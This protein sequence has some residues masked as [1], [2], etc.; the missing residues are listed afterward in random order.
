MTEYADIPG[1][2]DIEAERYVLGACIAWPEEIPNALTIFGDSLP[3]TQEN[4]LSIWN[5][6]AKLHASHTP[7]LPTEIVKLT[8][9]E[10]VISP[11][12]D[13]LV[14]NQIHGTETAY[15]SKRLLHLQQRRTIGFKAMA[16]IDAAANGTVNGEL[17]ELTAACVA[18]ASSDEYAPP[19]PPVTA[20]ELYKSPPIPIDWLLKPIFA[21]GK[22]TQ[23]QGEP[24]AG[25]SV[26]ALYCAICAV[27]GYWIAGE[28]TSH[29]KPLTVLFL[30][31]EDASNVLQ[32][33]ITAYFNGLGIG[34]PDD[35][36]HLVCYPQEKCYGL[37]I[38]LDTEDGRKNIESLV[39]YTAA[40]ILILDSLSNFNTMEENSKKEMQPVMARLRRIAHN[41]RC[42]LMYLHHIGKPQAGLQ[43]SRQAKSRGSG[44]IAAAWDILIDWGDRGDSDTTPMSL[45]SKLG[46]DGKWDVEY[47]KQEDGSIKWS[48]GQQL[49][50]ENST[51]I[52]RKIMDALKT[53]FQ[54]SP[55]GVKVSTIAVAIGIS[56]E[57]VRT[58]LESAFDAGEVE[59][60]KGPKNAWLYT[61]LSVPN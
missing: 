30:S 54:S 37:D 34:N 46:I 22:L 9:R 56:A 14:A 7:V 24:K 41:T 57:S 18:L 61:P 2:V 4:H 44:V 40:D 19:L 5:A 39:K 49:P 36:I 47:Q 42:A 32:E 16:L 6:L 11:F 59:R 15:Y 38:T 3:W 10:E 26:F 1:T 29:G 8:G 27:V 12:I 20:L 58:Y 17:E 13:S 25:K 52:M 51:A 53:L 48:L 43:K 23:L 50:R 31:S 45:M 35:L 55:E 60:E 21:R 33:R 28:F